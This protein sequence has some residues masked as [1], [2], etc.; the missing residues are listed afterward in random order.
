MVQLHKNFQ[1]THPSQ[2][3]ETTTKTICDLWYSRGGLHHRLPCGAFSVGKTTHEFWRR[4]KEHINSANSGDIYSAIGRHIINSHHHAPP[5]LFWALDHHS[6]Y[7]RGEDWNKIFFQKET[8]DSQ[9]WGYQ[10]PGAQWN[11][12]FQTLPRGLCFWTFRTSHVI[13]PPLASI[14]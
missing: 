3:S 2:R 10:S 6:P 14:S 5:P 7:P 11:H 1:S 4:I 9:Y 13:I 8:R 12:Q